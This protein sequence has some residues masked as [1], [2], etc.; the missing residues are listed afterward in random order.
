[1]VLSEQNI[2]DIE[3]VEAQVC[4]FFNI[5][6]DALYSVNTSKN[7]SLARAYLFYI[8]HIDLGIS[9]KCIYERYNRQERGVYYAISKI[10]YSIEHFKSCK[11]E[12]D[13]ITNR[14]NERRK[15]LGK[16]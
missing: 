8:L 5:P 13:E 2:R 14:F 10:R 7:E 1:M 12:Y 15:A 11:K 4:T 6:A 16:S 3:I 9:I